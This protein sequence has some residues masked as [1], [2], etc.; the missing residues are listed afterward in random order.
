M[1]WIVL[2]V[3]CL[4][5]FAV[6]VNASETKLGSL[7]IETPWARASA[8]SAAGAFLS[9]RN[10]GP[11]DKLMTVSSP[12]A[13]DVQLHVTI[14]DGDVMKMRAVDGLDV[15]RDGKAVLQPGG[16]H[17]MLMG[18]KAPLKEGDSLPLTLHFAKA[19]TV[20]IMVPVLKAGASE[21]AASHDHDHMMMDQQ[22]TH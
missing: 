9:I 12:L 4:L 7:I 13:A 17:I 5:G 21:P 6:S 2:F 22:H 19:G 20:E 1:K 16:S 3:A 14:K 8:G 15:P 18:L 11:D 10:E